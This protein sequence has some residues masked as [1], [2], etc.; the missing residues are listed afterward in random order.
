MVK[1]YTQELQQHT[2][3]AE[4]GILKLYLEICQKTTVKNITLCNFLSGLTILIR[5]V[6]CRLGHHVENITQVDLTS[7]LDYLFDL[8]ANAPSC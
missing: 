4:A 8:V 7:Y 1:T 5:C 2:V 3:A 6:C